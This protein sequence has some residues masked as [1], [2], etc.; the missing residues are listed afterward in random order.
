MYRLTLVKAWNTEEI[1]QYA[2]LV[3]RGNSDF[4]EVKGVNTAENPKH[5]TSNIPLHEEVTCVTFLNGC[6]FV[7]KVQFSDRLFIE[8][9][10]F[11]RAL[12]IKNC[13]RLNILHANKHALN[14]LLTK[15]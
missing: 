9:N 3:L 14:I 6:Y 8:Q 15:G 13:K 11:I 12:N 10:N 7:L 4:I 2:E 1:Q 5:L